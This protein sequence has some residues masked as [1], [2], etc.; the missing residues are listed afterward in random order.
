MSAQTKTLIFYVGDGS[1]GAPDRGV[2]MLTAARLSFC[3]QYCDLRDKDGKLVAT[4]TW[5]GNMK[6][7]ELHPAKVLGVSR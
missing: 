1:D 4:I 2:A 5:T 3:S 6:V 7:R